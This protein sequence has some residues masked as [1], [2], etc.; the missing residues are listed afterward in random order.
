MPLACGIVGL[1]NSGKS[2]LFNALTRAGAAVAG[3][4]FCTVDRNLGRVDVPDARLAVVQQFAGSAQATPTAIDVVDIA[5]LVRGAS[6]GEGLGNKF[7]GHI[8]DVDAILHVVRCFTND[9]APHYLGDVDPRRDVAVIITELL[10]A[11]MATIERRKERIFTAARTG[12]PAARSELQHLEMLTAA[13]DRGEEIR[14][15][16]LPQ[17]ATELAGELNLLTLKPQVL[18][19]NIPDPAGASGGDADGHAADTMPWP[20]AGLERLAAE[21]G[22]GFAMVYARALADLADM[23]DDADAIAAELG[24]S[25]KPLTELVQAAYRILRLLT[26][27][28]ANRNEARA[29][30]LRDGDDAISAAGRVHSDFARGFIAAEVIPAEAYQNCAN[31][32]EAQRLGLLRLEGRSYQVRDG[33]LLEFRV[34]L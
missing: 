16:D 15:V 32:A 23:G 19:A 5:G 21:R 34:N 31:R 13:L 18:V 4:P 2:T 24:I 8:R 25:A 1:P 33:D 17:R 20:A 26:F 3:Y 12:D 9:A 7:L 22:D 27:F 14:H 11:D 30:T 10:L 6:R 28:T 29:W